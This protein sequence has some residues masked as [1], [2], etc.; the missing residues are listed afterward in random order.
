MSEHRIKLKSWGKYDTSKSLESDFNADIITP[1]LAHKQTEKKILF[2]PSTANNGRLSYYIAD[3]KQQLYK[4]QTQRCAQRSLTKNI[5]GRGELN[6]VGAQ[7][8]M[9]LAPAFVPRDRFTAR[10]NGSLKHDN[11][12]CANL[13][14]PDRR[15]KGGRKE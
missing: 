4:H 8:V 7:L 15:G 2:K 5:S 14:I 6:E 10:E 12:L 11:F 1:I 3:K 13:A 9:R